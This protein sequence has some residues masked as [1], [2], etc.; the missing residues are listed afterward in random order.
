[1]PTRVTAVSIRVSAVCT[2]VAVTAVSTG[3]AVSAVVI[4]AAHRHRQQAGATHHQ[5]NDV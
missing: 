3:V 4:Q 1:M 5:W 2:R